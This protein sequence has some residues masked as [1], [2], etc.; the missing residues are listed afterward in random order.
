M[1]SSDV[2][3]VQLEKL[4]LEVD[5]ELEGLNAGGLRTIAEWL[6]EYESSSFGSCCF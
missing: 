3:R 4:G 6:G 2:T 5:A 1:A